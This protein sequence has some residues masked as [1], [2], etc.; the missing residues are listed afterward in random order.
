[1]IHVDD[2]EIET[3]LKQIRDSVQQYRQKKVSAL[4]RG[5]YICPKCRKDHFFGKTTTTKTEKEIINVYNFECRYKGCGFKATDKKTG[6]DSIID[7]YN[8]LIDRES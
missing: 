5:P 7:A 8:R 4:M 3:E 2:D 1:M 6:N